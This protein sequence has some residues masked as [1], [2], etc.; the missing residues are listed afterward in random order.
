M[1][2]DIDN[3][4]VHLASQSRLPKLNHLWL[5]PFELQHKLVEKIDFLGEAA[6]QGKDTRIVAK[7]NALTDEDLIV[8]LVKASTQEV[9]ATARSA[10]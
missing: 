3:V 9:P 2:S 10:S 8:A 1:T 4:F 6:L 7:M 5:A